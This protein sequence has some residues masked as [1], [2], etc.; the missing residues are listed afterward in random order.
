MMTG[1]SLLKFRSKDIYRPR[2]RYESIVLSCG[3]PDAEAT[4]TL[5]RRTILQTLRERETGPRR[6]GADTLNRK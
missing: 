5:Q 6:T 2:G 4:E 1:T 3:G